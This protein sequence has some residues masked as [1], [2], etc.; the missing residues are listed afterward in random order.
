M[1]ILPFG[2]RRLMRSLERHLAD[3]ATQRED[4][5]I[6]AHMAA[7]NASLGKPSKRSQARPDTMP[8]RAC[9]SP[10]RLRRWL[11]PC[12]ACTGGIHDEL[13]K[14]IRTRRTGR[15]QAWPAL[16][17]ASMADEEPLEV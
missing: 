7:V 9:T 3:Q 11:A 15:M 8:Y 6:V 5:A 14:R 2:Y 10:S 17:H 13:F 1:R 4:K 12:S 16:P